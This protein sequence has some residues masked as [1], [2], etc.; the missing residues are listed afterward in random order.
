MHLLFALVAT[1]G[2][3]ALERDL[4]LDVTPIADLD[5]L[6]AMR[7]TEVLQVRRDFGRPNVN[8]ALD[9]WVNADA[10]SIDGV[11]VWWSDEVDRYP[12]SEKMLRHLAIDYDR[13]APERWRVSVTGDGKQFAFDVALHEGRPAAFADVALPGGRSIKCCRA[14]S[15]S[16][17]ARKIFGIPIGVKSMVVTCTAPDGTEH[18]GAL[19]PVRAKRR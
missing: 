5:S 12:F 1:L 10:K 13:V 18:R 4:P 9:A 2:M 17:H 14:R 3:D 11:R 8:V 19:R 6:E 7:H 16:L 15:A